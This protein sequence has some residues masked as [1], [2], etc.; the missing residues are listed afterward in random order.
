MVLRTQRRKPKTLFVSLRET[1][2]LLSKHFDQKDNPAIW[3]L[4]RLS[5][6]WA[7]SGI[8]ARARLYRGTQ[9]CICLG[10]GEQRTENEL[11]FRCAKQPPTTF[12][13]AF[14]RSSEF[15]YG[16]RFFV[17]RQAAYVLRRGTYCVEN[18][19]MERKRAITFAA[20]KCGT[21]SEAFERG[22]VWCFE[23]PVCYGTRMYYGTKR[24][25]L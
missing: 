8:T 4:R 15:F 10:N 24:F 25:M 22:G 20:Q 12:S 18:A 9:R 5:S 13:K 7:Y 2:G 23:R 17:L 11:L 1:S 21:L 14:C 16:T 6:F 19:E 3:M